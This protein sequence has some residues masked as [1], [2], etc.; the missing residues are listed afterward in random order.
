MA[1]FPW[2][3][4][5]GS[6]MG[7]RQI[8][9]AAVLGAAA[10]LQSGV[11]WA[12]PW[13]EALGA[14]RSQLRAQPL[15]RDIRLRYSKA[16]LSAGDPAAARHHVMLMLH[17][18]R[19]PDEARGMLYALDAVDASDRWGFSL[20][21][22]LLPSDNVN[23]ASSARSI[24]TVFGRLRIIEGGE[25]KSGFGWTATARLRYQHVLGPG[26]R[27]APAVAVTRVAYPETPD[28]DRWI[29][30]PELTLSLIR[31][32]LTRSATLYQRRQNYHGSGSG[33]ETRTGARLAFRTIQ[34]SRIDWG[35]YLDVAR[36][37]R[38][39]ADYLDGTLI[40]A[41]GDMHYLFSDRL[42]GNLGVALSRRSARLDHNGYQGLWFSGGFDTALTR[43]EMVSVE[44]G[45]GRRLYDS[46]IPA[47]QRR[48]G[49][50]DVALTVGV[51]TG[52]VLIGG[53]APRL[54]CTYNKT[55]SNVELY[56]TQA[57]NCAL[58]LERQF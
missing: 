38:P 12:G 32:R 43:Q 11:G 39:F 18:A 31:P 55:F 30:S 40:R 29:I 33:D 56:Q 4:S 19:S 21:G 41:G 16:L 7:L 44:L 53:A 24:D 8:L 34:D 48:R 26:W 28:L 47:L 27:L 42:R 37:D 15:N 49:D 45:A 3:K 25:A 58:S 57:T 14:L 52:R 6:L 50:T 20:N 5:D 13:D 10:V 2:A 22:A 17:E 54:S 36:I 35:G 46:D 51:Q 9:G 1:S 23:G